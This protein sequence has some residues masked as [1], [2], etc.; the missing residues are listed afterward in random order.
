MM[1][2]GMGQYTEAKL[3][4]RI[5]SSKVGQGALLRCA[6]NM[7]CWGAL[8][9]DCNLLCRH[10]DVICHPCCLSYL[11]LL[12]VTCLPGGGTLAARSSSFL[13]NC[14]LLISS[15]SAPSMNATQLLLFTDPDVARSTPPGYTWPADGAGGSFGGNPAG[16]HGALSTAGLAG[17][18]IGLCAGLVL[19]GVVVWMLLMRR[20]R[21]R[22]AGVDGQM[23]L[24][25]NSFLSDKHMLASVDVG[26]SSNNNSM[27]GSRYC[28]SKDR[29]CRMGTNGMHGRAA[30][31]AA[32]STLTPDQQQQY[33]GLHTQ[34]IGGSIST[35]GRGGV[36]GKLDSI[37]GTGSNGGVLGNKRWQKLTNAISSKVQDIHQ[38]RLRTAFMQAQ[39]TGVVSLGGSNSPAFASRSPGLDWSSGGPGSSSSLQYAN[40]NNNNSGSN[41]SGTMQQVAGGG[42]SGASMSMF[43]GSEQREQQQQQMLQDDN[44]QDARD[45]FELKE[46]I[47]RGTF[48]MVYR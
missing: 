40:N 34:S 38:Q 25:S 17:L 29:D 13:D 46:L 18:I 6:S 45:T 9:C 5:S 48:G 37:S 47:G 3:K 28:S 21:R 26:G 14:C 27:Y 22:A 35:T 8:P 44:G 24:D 43:G 30:D 32:S 1:P 39:R 4:G 10:T 16:S 33:Q 41:N 19:V 42:G 20:S 7:A 12:L 31:V 36:S 2:G 11:L 23:G 15:Y